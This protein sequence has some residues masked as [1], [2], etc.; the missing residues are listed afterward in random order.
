MHGN[1]IKEEYKTTE[2]KTK[3][4]CLCSKNE[5]ERIKEKLVASYNITLKR[6]ERWS[7]SANVCP[8][9]SNS[10]QRPK[11]NDSIFLCV[12]LYRSLSPSVSLSLSMFF[13]GFWNVEKKT[14]ETE[15]HDYCFFFL[16]A[17]IFFFIESIQQQCQR[18]AFYSALW[19]C[20]RFNE[21]TIISH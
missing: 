4:N 13:S 5:W 7:N 9:S 17:Y 15:N 19:R 11:S 21:V 20:Q 14:H 10:N 2:H 3:P 8:V 18:K 6:H 16:P 12:T 1:R